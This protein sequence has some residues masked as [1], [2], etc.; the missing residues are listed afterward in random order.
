M[1]EKTGAMPSSSQ[2]AQ[3]RGVH[4]FDVAHEPVVDRL[5]AA[6]PGRDGVSVGARQPEGV[7]S[8][9]LQSGHRLLVDKP[10]VNHRHHV[11]RSLV[12]DAASVD[13]LHLQLQPLGQPRGQFSA[14]VHEYFGAFQRG[15]LLQEA[16]HRRGVVD[17]VAAYFYDYDPFHQF[18]PSSSRLSTTWAAI[19]R[20]AA[21]GITSER[22]DSITSS[23]TI[24]LRLTGRQCMKRALFVSAIFSASTVHARSR[25]STLP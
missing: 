20:F 10:G 16:F 17:D 5:G 3:Q 2:P 4:P 9:G 18:R 7:A 24:M 23:V 12:G 11:K 25:D 13:H 14:S 8:C 1:A 22:G 6:A 19:S 15:E 21:S